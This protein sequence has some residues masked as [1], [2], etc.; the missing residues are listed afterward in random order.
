MLGFF[1]RKPQNPTLSWRKRLAVCRQAWERPM[2]SIW[3]LWVLAAAAL[4]VAGAVLLFSLDAAAAAALA[5]LFPLLVNAQI[6]A[7]TYGFA[8]SCAYAPPPALGATA[9]GTAKAAAREWLATFVLFVL[10]QPFERWWMGPEALGPRRSGA[11]PLLLIH[12][13]L[14]NRGVWW[15]LRRGLRAQGRAVATIDLE[16]PLGSIETLAEVLDARLRALTAET[17]AEKV[18][19]VGHSMGGLAARAHLRRH[20]KARVARLVT[21]GTPHH[22]TQLARIGLGHNAREMVPGSPWIRELNAAGPPP[23][24]TLSVWS[25]RDNYIA[26]QDSSRL[27]GAR[28]VVLP[29]LGHLSMLFSP[30]VL[31]VLLDETAE[32]SDA[33]AAH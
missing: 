6:V 3:L 17:G 11:P 21:L 25:A 2:L 5:V 27:A 10:I 8:L 24:Q 16:P 19:L 20:G 12:G 14:C 9:W 26:P 15:W 1:W 13:Y 28:E 4:L 31:Q 7:V 33:S 32:T 29:T 18:V 30:R 23:V 22:G